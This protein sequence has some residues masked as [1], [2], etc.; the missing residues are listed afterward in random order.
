MIIKVEEIRSA[1]FKNAGVGDMAILLDQTERLLSKDY[2]V[3][4]W[5]IILNT[6]PASTSHALI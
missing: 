1:F 6:I 2:C 4:W 5:S 3:V